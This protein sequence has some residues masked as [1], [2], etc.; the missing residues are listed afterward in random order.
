MES[1]VWDGVIGRKGVGIMNTHGFRLVTLCREFNLAISNTIFRMKNRYKTSW[2]HPRSKHWHLM[3]YVL[4]LK[5]DPN[6]VKKTNA[7]IIAECLKHHRLIASDHALELR[8]ISRWTV[9]NERK[10]NCK[11]LLDNSTRIQFQGVVRYALQSIYH[12]PP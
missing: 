7:I 2:M 10:I 5:S 4:V 8:Q 12:P 11:A 3:D 9:T 6:F 1:A